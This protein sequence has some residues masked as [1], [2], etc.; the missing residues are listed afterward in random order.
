MSSTQDRIDSAARNVQDG[1]DAGRKLAKRAA[2]E[3]DDA[4]DEVSNIA[5]RAAA[6]AGDV[7]RG[8]IDWMRDNSDR[9]RTE[10]ARAGDRTVDYIRDQPVRSVVAAAATGALVY[11]VIQALRGRRG[12]DY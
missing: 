2:H 7:A 11:A 12:R 6:R 1:V 4:T 5:S 10:V 3:L 9:V 8:S